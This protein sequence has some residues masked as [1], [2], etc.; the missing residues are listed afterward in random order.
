MDVVNYSLS[1]ILYYQP[2]IT[3]KN[4]FMGIDLVASTLMESMHSQSSIPDIYIK[5]PL[6]FEQF[7][8]P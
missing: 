7:F 3:L 1:I 5:N 4:L 8:P 2:G 6:S